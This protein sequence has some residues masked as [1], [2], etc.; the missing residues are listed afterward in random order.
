M[1]DVEPAE[2]GLDWNV[3]AARE[4][5]SNRDRSAQE[6]LALLDVAAGGYGNLGDASQVLW[7]GRDDDINVLRTPHHAPSANR[8]S[9]D[10]HELCVRRNE[11]AKQLVESRP[12]QI[13]R[14]AP[15]NRI[16]L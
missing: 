16:S 6:S 12:R 11:A 4:G 15:A 5:R 13:R 10:D 14:A 8:Q 2:I 7:L 1:N 3:L 9:T